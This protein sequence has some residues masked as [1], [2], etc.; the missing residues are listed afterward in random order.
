[1]SICERN[2]DYDKNVPLCIEL[3]NVTHF[4]PHYHP[5]DLE[6]IFCMRG[7]VSIV[8][9]FEKVQLTEGDFFTVNHSE[10]HCIQSSDT[11][12]IV[13]T[14]HL[15]LQNC[16]SSEYGM[17]EDKLFI[18]ESL[19]GKAKQ[20]ALFDDALTL[21]MMAAVLYAENP[22]DTRLRT[23]AYSITGIFSDYFLYIDYVNDYQPFAEN[24]REISLKIMQ[25]LYRNYRNKISL[26]AFAEEN[27]FDRAHLAHL[28]KNKL[29]RTFNA[30]LNYLR[31]VNA[32]FLLLTTE[33]SNEEISEL[34]GFSDIKYFYSHFRAWYEKTPSQYRKEFFD[35]YDS[36]D[37][38]NFLKINE[39]P[40]LAK[41]FLF[42]YFT[43]KVTVE[44]PFR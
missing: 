18:F 4:A 20:P 10:I 5:R 39:I 7:S 35:I 1:M 19:N 29:H 36:P 26:T 6:I 41:D 28:L 21:I 32:E 11:D 34:C 14:V 12:N 2:I 38:C 40:V 13:M 17:P 24:T 33:K 31:C 16:A 3:M 9:S 22:E 8:S 27:Y 43:G 37:D 44:Y 42:K 25:Y 23:L 30:C 15:D